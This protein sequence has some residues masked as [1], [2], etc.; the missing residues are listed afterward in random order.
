MTT[1]IKIVNI[2]NIEH[3]DL[4]SKTTGEQFSQSAV[5]SS[6]FDLK[7][8]FVHH[9]ILSPGIKSSS[10]HS[11]TK[12]EEMALVLIG[13]PTI[14]VGNQSAQ[15]KPGDVIGLKPLSEAYYFENLTDYEVQILMMCS[16]PSDDM[17][18]Y[19]P[20]L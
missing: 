14:H 7:D 9:E 15:L 16:N 2:K 3:R 13:N 11:H 8:L 5:L 10:A 1:K 12:R 18:M 17:V 20:A 4:K 19:G 6:L